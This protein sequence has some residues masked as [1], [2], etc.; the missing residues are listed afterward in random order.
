MKNKGFTVL[1]VLIAMTVTAVIISSVYFSFSNI[2]TGKSRTKERLNGI[3]KIFFTVELIR[4][5]ME[6]AFLTSHQGVPEIT[7]KTIFKSEEDEPV[8][9]VT[10][11]S[12][13]HIKMQENVKEC[14]QTEIEYYGEEEDG[15]NVLY[16]RESS[17]VDG[18]PEKGGQTFPI[19][20]GFEKIVFEYWNETDKDWRP[21]WN[22]ESMDYS[23]SLPPKIKLTLE[24]PETDSETKPLKVE[25]VF[26]IKMKRPLTF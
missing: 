22:S 16:R 4:K 15:V 24:M 26:N 10:F 17:W 25:T 5:D 12:F 18:D 14:S 20:K 11:T 8:T 3:R 9:H 21:L 6:N 2:L 19:L 23:N 1:E 13:N 7:H